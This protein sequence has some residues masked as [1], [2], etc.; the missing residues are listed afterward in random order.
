MEK[1]SATVCEE[2][3]GKEKGKGRVRNG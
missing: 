1:Q 3:G 2:V